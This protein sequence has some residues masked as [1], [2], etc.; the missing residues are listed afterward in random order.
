[1]ARQVPLVG[2]RLSVLRE[3]QLVPDEVH[4]IGRILPVVDREVGIEADLL[5]VLAQQPRADRRGT[6]R[7]R[8]APPS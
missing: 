6:S 1:M 2:N 5:G 4:Q 3:A 8:R 7:P